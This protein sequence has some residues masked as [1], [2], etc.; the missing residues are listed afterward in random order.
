MLKNLTLKSKIIL[1]SLLIAGSMA[2]LGAYALKELSS[3]NTAVE[4]S[5]NNIDQQVGVL[6]NI[7]QAHVNFKIQVQEWKNV[8]IRGNNPEQYDKYFGRFIKQEQLVQ[9]DLQNAIDRLKTLGKDY[10]TVTEIKIEHKKLGEAYRSALNSFDKTKMTTGQDVDKLVSGVDRPASKGMQELAYATEESF[11]ELIAET[12]KNTKE[13]ADSAISNFLISASVFIILVLAVVIYVFYDI[14]RLLGGEPSYAAEIVRNVADGRLDHTIDINA[15][16]K[17]SLIHNIASMRDRLVDIVSDVKSSADALASASEEVNATAQNL[18]QGAS[19][20]AA[21]VEETSAAMEEM[22]ASITQNNENATVT[23][24]MA[25]KAAEDA[26]KGGNAVAET[27]DAMQ[28]IAERISVIDDI[29]YQTNLLALNAAIEAGRAGEH[30]KGFAV[31]ASEVRKLAERSQV[32]AQD[33]GQLATASVKQAELAGALLEKIVPSI[34]KT[35]DLVQEISAASAEQSS[36]VQQINAAIGQVSTTMQQNAASSEQLSATSEEMSG[37]ALSLK[38][39]I[40]YFVIPNVE[41]RKR[42]SLLGDKR[43]ANRTESSGK[44]H[45]QPQ[46]LE[47][48][49][50]SDKDDLDQHFTCFSADE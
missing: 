19:T 36:G 2:I 32:A 9:D 49:Q 38:E 24:G 50:G 15:H 28:Q 39:N 47:K 5:I 13:R 25:Q 6:M 7:E 27:V 37:H 29:A 46:T 4:K 41:Q 42:P 20:Q 22:S 1:L 48:T 11:K 33:I 18:A 44:N 26:Q 45:N 21:S 16:F 17:N 31:V 10:N 23:D 8:L 40:D 30:G 12:Q 34:T 43:E 3:L 35:A 14:Y